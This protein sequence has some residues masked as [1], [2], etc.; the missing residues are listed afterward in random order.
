MTSLIPHFA[1]LTDLPVDTIGCIFLFVASVSIQSFVCFKQVSTTMNS[2]VSTHYCYTNWMRLKSELD[3]DTEHTHIPE[4]GRSL[5]EYFGY[6]CKSGNEIYKQLMWN[7]IVV[8][9]FCQNH[10]FRIAAENGHLEIV[11]YLVTNAPEKVDIHDDLD[12]AISNV[13]RNKH[14]HILEFLIQTSF[15]PTQKPYDFRNQSILGTIAY[16]ADITTF[17]IIWN[18]YVR[19]KK[20]MDIDHKFLFKSLCVSYHS[21]FCGEIKKRII[22][23]AK[24]L[25][26]THGISGLFKLSTETIDQLKHDVGFPCILI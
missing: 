1:V 3:A 13:I 12:Y 19:E 9:D 8:V 25:Y 6:A 16:H 18:T 5:Q 15:Q 2:L 26:G 14:L 22:D 20:E 24:F 17:G 4:L 11:K 21:N 23:L 10:P 7:D